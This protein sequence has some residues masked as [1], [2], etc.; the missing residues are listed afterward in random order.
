M[1]SG[2]KEFFQQ[3]QK[4][5]NLR[6]CDDERR[7]EAQREIVSAVDEQ[8][9]LHGLLDKGSAIDGKLDANHQA[10]ATNFA[11]E[12]EFGGE[13]GQAVAQLGAARLDVFEKVFVVD[14]IQ[15]FKRGGAGERA[16]AESGAVQAG[17]NR[18]GRLLPR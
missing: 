10:F 17:R 8:A 18:A 15:K 13:R 14:D 7:K 3:T 12:I 9:A 6:A 2:C 11:D 16:A 4:L 5:A 1:R